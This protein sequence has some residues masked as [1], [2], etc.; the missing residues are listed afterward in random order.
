MK[1]LLGFVA[2]GLIQIA[3]ASDAK[4]CKKSCDKCA[5]SKCD[6]YRPTPVPT[7][8]PTPTPTR[9]PTP[10]PTVVPSPTADI[11]E[12]VSVAIQ[13]PKQ[14]QIF[15]T[16]KALLDPILFSVQNNTGNMYRLKESIS[17]A[18]LDANGNQGGIFLTAS[19]GY[20]NI[21][22]MSTVR[23][24]LRTNMPI[25]QGAGTYKVKLC[26]DAYEDLAPITNPPTSNIQPVGDPKF[27]LH[28][29]TT[30]IVVV[31]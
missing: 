14:I 16:I 6:P 3:S 18:P 10:T 27:G 31:D 17:S 29:V 20:V 11:I 28:C 26:V 30:N 9:P 19:T 8:V 24:N 7:I 12:I 13:S 21:A 15:G 25:V 2:L 5:S 22:A 4:D 1:K 23:W